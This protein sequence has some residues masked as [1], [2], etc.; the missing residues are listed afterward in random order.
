MTVYLGTWYNMETNAL[1]AKLSDELR[2]EIEAYPNVTGT[3]VGPKQVK[4]QGMTDELSLIVYVSEKVEE[5]SLGNEEVIPKEVTIDGVTYKTD[6]QGIGETVLAAAIQAGARVEDDQSDDAELSSVPMSLSRTDKW[7]PASAGISVGHPDI[8]AGT[9]GSPPLLT[10]SGEMVFLTNSHVAA[11]SGQASVGDEILQPGVADGGE[12]DDAIGTLLEFSSF[13]TTEDNT[14][15]SALV[16][17]RPDHLEE[18]VFELRGDLR[19]WED[20]EI[21]RSY[22]KSGR[23]TG[24][25]RGRCTARGANVQIGGSRFVGIDVFEPMNTGGDSGSL[26]VRESGDELYGVSLLFASS[27]IIGTDIV[28]RTFAIPMEAVQAE[29]GRL[30]PVAAQNVVRPHDLEVVGTQYSGHIDAGQSQ[31]VFTFNWPANEVVHWA[32][33]PTTDGARL[34]S[35]VMIERQ[36]GDRI[37]YHIT[38]EN[39]GAVAS[40]YELRFARL[41]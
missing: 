41:R 1:L 39:V 9:L 26:I 21:G 8:T 4:G 10:E 17:I 15:D 30:T 34:E 28:T 25:T 23:T 31:R 2:D 20:A 32:A 37:T 16:E 13:S 24:V 18:D 7:R 40:D 36:S 22:T 12:S 35:S 3:A 38:V 27:R 5:S 6:V 33:Y 11:A 14:T 19:G 29:H